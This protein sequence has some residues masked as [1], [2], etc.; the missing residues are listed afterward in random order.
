MNTTAT[1]NWNFSVRFFHWLTF[2]LVL[3]QFVLA[4]FMDE[5]EKGAAR[6]SVMGLHKSVGVTILLLVAVRL[7]LRLLTKAPPD[8]APGSLQDRAA[9]L[10]HL[11]LYV[12]LV[13]MPVSGMVVSMAG[14]HPVSWFGLWQ[15]P[16]FVAASDSLKEAAEEAHELIGTAIFILVGLH[17]AAALWHHYKLKDDVLRRMLLVQK[18]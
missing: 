18:P 15:L 13:A 16:S 3:G 12:L 10:V 5:M 9:K 1:Q 17:A 8:A 2:L 11:L 14:G 6:D 4:A 7:G